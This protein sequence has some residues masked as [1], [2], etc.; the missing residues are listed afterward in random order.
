VSRSFTV[1][2]H[3]ILICCAIFFAAP[4][5]LIVVNAVKHQADIAS[6]PFGI[7]FGRLT[8]SNL[9]EVVTDPDANLGGAYIL[10]GW[11]TTIGVTLTVFLGS[12]LGYVLARSRHRWTNLLYLVLLAGILVPPEATLLPLIKLLT[13]INLMFT[14]QG[15][16]AVQVASYLPLAVL[17]YVGFVRTLPVELEEAARVDGASQLQVYRRVVLPLLAPATITV[18]IIIGLISLTDFVTPSVVLGTGSNTIT[19]AINYAIGRFST[20]YEAIY[21]TLWWVT[22][23]MIVGFVFLQRRLVGGLTEGAL[24]N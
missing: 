3:F 4:I 18:A 1:A 10:T 11:I 19:T 20:D 16:I 2:R 17:L 22:I 6:D 13:A 12:A 7:P 23:P 24:R 21:A 9:I 5:Y 14:P 15:L 8:I